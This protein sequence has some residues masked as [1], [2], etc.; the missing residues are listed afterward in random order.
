MDQKA[1]L[2]KKRDLFIATVIKNA[3]VKLHSNDMSYYWQGVWEMGD[4]YGY[5][6]FP[7]PKWQG[8]EKGDG[9]WARRH[10]G[11]SSGIYLTKHLLELLTIVSS[12][13][14]AILQNFT[15]FGTP[16]KEDFKETNKFKSTPLRDAPA[17]AVAP[18]EPETAP[19]PEATPEP[20]PGAE[21]EV[22]EPTPAP[23]P[24][25]SPAPAPEPPKPKQKK[26]PVPKADPD[27][28][29]DADEDPEVKQRERKKDDTD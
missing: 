28:V 24:E 9:T 27:V 10:I 22:Q 19:A 17:T 3:P 23:E 16:G 15:A 6:L 21:P 14:M 11:K 25:T 26:T 5:S 7:F 8:A 2:T 18:V 1:S 20:A 12:N 4:K 13:A 29:L